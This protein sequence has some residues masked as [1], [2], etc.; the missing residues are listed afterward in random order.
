MLINFT[1]F[2]QFQD[3]NCANHMPVFTVH[4]F[5]TT[6][7]IFSEHKNNSNPDLTFKD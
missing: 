2:L 5:G 7:S 6:S 1:P 3:L 4:D